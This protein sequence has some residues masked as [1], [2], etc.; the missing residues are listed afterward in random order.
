MTTT[1]PGPLVEPVGTRGRLTR[2]S[3]RFERGVW[4]LAGALMAILVV[5]I[6]FPIVDLALMSINS[7]VCGY[8]RRSRSRS[9]CAFSHR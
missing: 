1:P 6:W 9:A 3:D 5:W 8:H 7:R 4:I 2:V